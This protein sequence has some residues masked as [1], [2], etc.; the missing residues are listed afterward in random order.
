MHFIK[1]NFIFVAYSSKSRCREKKKGH[2]LRCPFS[3]VSPAT[4]YSPTR[5]PVQYHRR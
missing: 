4:F 3:N 2:F 1:K 5:S